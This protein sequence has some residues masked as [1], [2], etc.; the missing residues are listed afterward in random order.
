M[1]ELFLIMMVGL[2][3]SGKSTWARNMMESKGWPIVNPDSIRLSL[4]GQ[5]FVA[6]AEPF[7]WAIARVM[8]E[9]LFTAGHTRVI[10]DATN[11]VAAH[12]RQWNGSWRLAHKVIDTSASE[13]I[14]RAQNDQE[15][16]SVIAK[17]AQEYDPLGGL[18][19]R[20]EDVL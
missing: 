7:V 11:T 2:P 3:R 14:A 19:E 6:S 15:I 9:S 16:I 13:C 4:H 1:P 20:Y 12:R 8:V 17:M 5:R 10:L 18:D